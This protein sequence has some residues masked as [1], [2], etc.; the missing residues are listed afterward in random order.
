MLSRVGNYSMFRE[1]MTEKIGQDLFNVVESYYNIHREK[2]ETRQ[3]LINIFIKYKV[4]YIN[5]V[6][7][8]KIQNSTDTMV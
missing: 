2:H 3:K 5:H 7:E 6:S 8:L 4:P 1:F